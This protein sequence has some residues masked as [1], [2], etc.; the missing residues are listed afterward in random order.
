MT[1]NTLKMFVECVK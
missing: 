1:T